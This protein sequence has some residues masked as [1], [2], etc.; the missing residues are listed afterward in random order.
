MLGKADETDCDVLLVEDDSAH[1]ELVCRA[2]EARATSNVVQHVHD[3]EAAL[4]YLFR[5]GAF[6][7]PNSS[8]RPKVVLLD[9]RLPRLG[10]LEVLARIRASDDL[11]KMPV[12]ILTTS[13]A[14]PDIEQAYGNH[15][16]SYL[17]KPTDFGE[18]ERLMQDFGEY[19]LGWNESP[20]PDNGPRHTG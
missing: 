17:V 8:P 7:D 15:A 20:W 3:G 6:A 13:N 12:V 16:S 11:A 14:T 4:D 18:F 5:Q 9:L 1:A 19:W 2:F 10:G